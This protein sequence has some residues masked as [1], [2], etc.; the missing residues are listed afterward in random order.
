MSVIA[1]S[2]IVP[3]MWRGF[4][5]PSYPI[6]TYIGNFVIIGDATGGNMQI[7]FPFKIEGAPSTGL[8]YNIEQMSAFI[9]VNLGGTFDGFIR[10]LAFEA[11]GP[12][13]IG[14][15]SYR[16][17]FR[18]GSSVLSMATDVPPM[19]IFLGQ[20]ARLATSFSV[21]QIGTGNIN[22]TILSVDIQGYIWEPR[23]VLA[24]G[25]LKRPADNLY[26]R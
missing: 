23:S 22:I 25:G 7:Q 18:G 1:D 9:S 6:G 4:D 10:I 8:F 15:R 13:I 5:D 26:G 12:F 17:E 11:L 19:P 14:D 16:F 21:V 3:R 24:E 20:S 2:P